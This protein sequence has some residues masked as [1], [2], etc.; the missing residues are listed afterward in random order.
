MKTKKSIHPHL[1]NK[2]TSKPIKSCK[3]SLLTEQKYKSRPSPACH[4]NNCK[5]MVMF[6]NDKKL[7]ISKPDTRNI[8]KWIPMTYV[9]DN[10]RG[11]TS[12][13]TYYTHDNG[14][15]PFKVVI[16]NKNINCKELHIY[17]CNYIDTNEDAKYQ[18]YVYYDFIT[19]YKVDKIFIGNDPE[20]IYCDQLNSHH[21]SAII[22]EI[23]KHKYV[24]IGDVVY[25]FETESPIIMFRS[26]IGNNDVPYPFAQDNTFTYLMNEFVKLHNSDLLTIGEPFDPYGRYYMLND[27][28]KSLTKLIG[29]KFQTNI[30]VPRR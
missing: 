6:G 24:Y 9:D 5:D 3:S 1:K 23:G 2:W 10:K 28:Y 7:Y 30:I 26:P 29:I 4:A 16:K 14:S 18:D 13:N 22:A 17:G 11:K 20:K 8:Y 21:G 19:K 15:R 12:P 25:E 27:K